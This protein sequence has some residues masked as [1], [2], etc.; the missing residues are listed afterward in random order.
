M[1]QEA[2]R[3]AGGWNSRRETRVARAVIDWESE[4]AGQG[5]ARKE[6]GYE[7]PKV[8]RPEAARRTLLWPT[9]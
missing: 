1:A 4:E 9:C 6:C 7:E 5:W 3:G 8:G 2:E